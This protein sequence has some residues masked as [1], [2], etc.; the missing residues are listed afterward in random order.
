MITTTTFPGPRRRATSSA[1][2]TAVPAEPPEKMP[3]R[4]ASWRT[5]TKE[6]R[7]ETSITSSMTEKSRVPTM[8]SWPIPST[9]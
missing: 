2:W 3:S 9:R 8:K 7:S 1:P 6:S 5:V 4:R